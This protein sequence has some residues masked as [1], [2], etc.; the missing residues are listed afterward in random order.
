MITL[1]N[2]I[3]QIF[4]PT[5][6]DEDCD[7]IAY[8][9]DPFEEQIKS[10]LSSGNNLAAIE[11][12]LQLLFS[13]AKHF[14]EDEHWCYFDD[15]YAPDYSCMTIFQ[16]FKEAI[17]SGNLSKEEVHTLQEGL[18]IIANMESVRDYGYPS[19]CDQMQELSSLR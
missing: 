19:L 7:L 6:I 5:N 1:N 13:L 9:M 10:D 15:L 16:Y 8:L 4:S 3:E 14:I 18:K 12:F 17:K 2:S 11:L